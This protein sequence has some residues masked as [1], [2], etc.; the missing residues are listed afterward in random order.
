MKNPR[1]N[2]PEALNRRKH[3]TL[4]FGLALLVIVLSLLNHPLGTVAQEQN[5][6]KGGLGSISG[7]LTIQGKLAPGIEVTLLPQ[8]YHFKDKAIATCKTD[9]NG[10][11]QFTN[12]PAN[13]YWLKVDA[14]GYANLDKKAWEGPG[15]NV[16]IADGEV[17]DDADLDLVPSGA[18][19][20]RITDST[21][22]PVVGEEVELTAVGEYGPY[23]HS[24]YL[25]SGPFK[26]ESNG[27]FKLSGI[28]PGQYLISIGVDIARLR[29][30][31]WDKN[32]RAGQFGRVAGSHYYEQT[33]YPGVT[34]R[35]QAHIVSVLPGGEITGLNITV[36]KSL[37]TFT[38]SGRVIDVQ[39]GKGL[40]NRRLQVWQRVGAR[41]YRGAMDG[42]LKVEKTDEGGNFHL[43]G[44][45]PGRFFIGASLEDSNSDLYSLKVDFEIKETDIAGLTVRVYHGLTLEGTVVIAGEAKELAT[46]MLPE[47]KIDAWLSTSVEDPADNYR[48]AAV[49]KD[50]SFK[51]SGLR[52]GKLRISLTGA[53]HYFSIARVELPKSEDKTQMQIVEASSLEEAQLEIGDNNLKAVRLVLTYKNASIKGHVTVV[54]GRLPAEIRLMA[55]IYHPVGTGGG[56]WW[57]PECDANGNFSLD[58][59]EPGDYEIEISDGGRSFTETKSV[60]VK[61]GTVTEVP[62]TVNLAKQKEH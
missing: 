19:T 40:A 62:F 8:S 11:Y 61:K 4:A 56:F 39:T 37:P 48:E 15:R 13:H 32:D 60:K 36:S 30:D 12:L 2:K 6:Q 47:L 21:G 26:T 27:T 7:H 44:M 45:V 14:P 5:Q 34:V 51:I 49:G 28:P 38:A 42:A 18:I 20:G 9:A 54:G 29:G 1:C 3:Q 24:T 59:L 58:G 25:P 55:R 33:F 23:T 46:S 17:V 41:G 57:M 50:G 52:Q 10:R 43:S 22:N 16:T 31:V 35:E 53:S